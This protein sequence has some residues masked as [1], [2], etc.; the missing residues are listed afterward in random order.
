MESGFGQDEWGDDSVL[1]VSV[2][3][4]RFAGLPEGEQWQVQ[5]VVVG[6]RFASDEVRRLQM[7][8]GPEGDLYMWM[9]FHL[10]LH[11]ASID[12]YAYNVN[13]AAP[14]V[15]VVARQDG[16]ELRPLQVTVSLDDAQ[17][18]DATNL[19]DAEETVHRVPMP[20]E[21]YHWVERFVVN[22]YVPR[23]RK[24]SN[25][26]TNKSIFDAEVNK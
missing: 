11:K 24:F 1:P 14:T 16:G 4:A 2:I 22:N 3:V 18:L 23:K 5:G 10:R 8:S 25:R 7:R 17:N 21:V 13:S 9:G 26:R 6:Q 20:P 12:G 19:R 15:F